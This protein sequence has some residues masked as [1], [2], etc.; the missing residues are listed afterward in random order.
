ML[1]RKNLWRREVGDGD[2]VGVVEG[3]VKKEAR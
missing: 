1:A 3:V 2:E